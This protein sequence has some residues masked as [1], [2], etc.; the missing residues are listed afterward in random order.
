MTPTEKIM[1]ARSELVIMAGLFAPFAIPPRLIE[2]ELVDTIMTDGDNWYFNPHWVNE[3]SKFKMVVVL[4]HECMH[5]MDAHHLRIGDRDHKI[6]NI[7]ADYSINGSLKKWVEHERG[8]SIN[9]PWPDDAL[10]DQQFDGKTPEWI[11]QHLVDNAQVVQVSAPGGAGDGSGEGSGSEGDGDTQDGASGSQGG[12][13]GQDKPLPDKGGM[14]GVVA[15]TDDQG[16]TLDKDK[17]EQEKKSVKEKLAVAVAAA[18][19]CG[20][21]PGSILDLWEDKAKPKINWQKQLWDWMERSYNPEEY[22]F[23]RNSTFWYALE[24]MYL[25]GLGSRELG[26]FV[27]VVDCS[28]SISKEEAQAFHNERRGIRAQCEPETTHLLFID[29]M[30][31]AEYTFDQYDDD[32]VT[33]KLSGGG[34]AFQPAFDWVKKKGIQPAGMVYLTDM[35]A[36]FPRSAPDYPVLWLS[37]TKGINAPWGKTV[38]MEV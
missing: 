25:P 5:V 23:G 38:Y 24:D 37:T 10:W 17:V 36:P 35:Y 20:D 11:Y 15:K 33:P 16:E 30:V 19:S 12:A 3:Q 29:T 1:K 32:K 8:K 18:K 7:A 2:T 6:W 26:E 14:G 34:T 28:G 22:Q 13:E 31:Q 9:L 27:W 21:M 4:A